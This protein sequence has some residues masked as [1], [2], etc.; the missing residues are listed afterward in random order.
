MRRMRLRGAL[1]ATLG[2]IATTAL[3][4]AAA[5]AAPANAVVMYSESGD[6]IGGGQ[7]RL[8]HTGNA[9]ISVSGSTAYL[10]VNVSGGNFGDSYSLDF[11]APPGETLA[12]GVYDKAQR[13]PF[14]ESTRPGIDIGGDGR[15][16]NTISGRFEVKDIAVSPSGVLE[17]LWI[18]YEQHC[19]G[20]TPA[21]FGEVRLGVDS[22]GAAYATPAVVRW[23]V[24]DLGRPGMAVP[25]T[26]VAPGGVQL[27]G[28][29]Q[30]GDHPGDFPLRV[31]ECS[32]RALPAGGQCEVWVRF[33]PTASGT[34]TAILRIPEAG[35][36]VQ[37]IALQGFTYGGRTRLV[38]NS[39]S[40]DYIGGGGTYSYTPENALIAAGGTRRGVGFGL[41]AAN[42]DDWSGSFSPADGDIIAPGRYTGAT[43]DA[44]RGT[45]PGIE[46]T[47][48]GRG[49]NEIEGEF[50]VHEATFD[51]DG[52]MRSIALDFVQHC[53]G[54]APALRGTFEYRAGDSTPPP[55]WMVSGPGTTGPP[56]S[57][58]QPGG[59]GGDPTTPPT[60]P[61]PASARVKSG[62]CALKRYAELPLLKGTARADRLKGTKAGEILFAG[63]GNDVVSAGAGDDCVDGGAGRDA[64]GGGSGA[65][66]LYGAAGNDRLDGG[67]GKDFLN[68]GPGRDVA[69]VTK[70]DRTKG[71]E[72]IVRPRKKG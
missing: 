27:G 55:P 34:R 33:A 72:R 32:G 21:L 69:T 41:D 35:G 1:L 30:G 25:V 16:C 47:G 18:V 15:G 49:C 17:R 5:H 2:A 52:R 63:R 8:F 53:E 3:G 19:E 13:A 26:L 9:Q 39:D 43:R 31:D 62:P 36:H 64:L 22:G 65:D 45:G 7:N 68:C 40:G 4:P 51:P 60:T 11:A 44:F 14:R 12:R 38:M 66:Y 24:S 46:V 57:I 71:C 28:V 29:S 70:G 50:T 61:P 42:G 48:N 59:G 20:G 6:Y 67:A 54:G 56:T 23:P 58:G 37:E 10:T